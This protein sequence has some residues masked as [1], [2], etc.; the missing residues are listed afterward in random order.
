M[1][2]FVADAEPSVVVCSP[3]NFDWILQV[4]F[5]AGIANFKAPKQVVFVVEVQRN[6]M[7]KP[8]K[9]FP[10]TL[11]AMRYEQCRSIS[12]NNASAAQFHWRHKKYTDQYIYYGRFS[13]IGQKT[14]RIEGAST[15][16]QLR[17]QNLCD[18]AP[19]IRCNRRNR[20]AVATL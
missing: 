19:L 18:V 16:R 9:N 7:G 14:C 6:T 1:T 20:K 15:N 8:Q 12:K 5:K 11:Y 3:E 10:R 2:I 17:Q 13:S 4:A